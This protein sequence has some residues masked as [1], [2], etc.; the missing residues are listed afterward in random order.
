MHARVATG[1]K[2]ARRRPEGWREPLTGRTAV[3]VDDGIA[4][5][6]TARAACQ[7]ARAQG[8]PMN[9]LAAVQAHEQAQVY[10]RA[11]RYCARRRKRLE[12]GEVYVRRKVRTKV[13]CS[14]DVR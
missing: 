10:A 4:T 11:A 8:V 14:S 13:P 2:V 6:S 7:V 1:Q 5:G 9:E 12:R 3:A